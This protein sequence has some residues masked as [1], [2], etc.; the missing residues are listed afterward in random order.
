MKPFWTSLALVL[1]TLLNTAGCSTTPEEQALALIQQSG[2]TVRKDSAGNVVSVD[3]SDSSAGDNVLAVIGFF[4]HV[5]TINCTNNARING[6]GLVALAGL[7]KLETLYLVNTAVDDGGI[8]HVSQLKSLKT[9]N[10]S[11]TR[12]T[13]VGMRALDELPNLQ[14]LG[15][16]RTVVS[17]QGLVQLRDLRKL[18]TVVLRDTKTSKRG[19]Q[20]LHRMLPDVRVVD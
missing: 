8:A 5:H 17:D 16:G 1:A 11:G 19:V 3:L 13:D 15:L 9:L 6:S 14:T 18:S 10:L 7:S 4:P 2:G 20:A 12:I